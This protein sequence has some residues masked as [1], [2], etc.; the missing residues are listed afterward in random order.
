MCTSCVGLPPSN[1]GGT[2]R[3]G[4]INRTR[5]ANTNPR[6]PAFSFCVPTNTERNRDRPADDAKTGLERC[7][8]D[9]QII[10][11]QWPQSDVAAGV[12]AGRLPAFVGNTS[13]FRVYLPLRD[14]DGGGLLVDAG[15]R[16]D[17]HRHL[18][19]TTGTPACA[20]NSL[21][22]QYGLRPGRGSAV[23]ISMHGRSV[24]PGF[25]VIMSLPGAASRAAA[26][27][28]RVYGHMTDGH[29]SRSLAAPVRRR[30]SNLVSAANSPEGTSPS[31]TLADRGRGWPILLS[32]IAAPSGRRCY[33]TRSDKLEGILMPEL[34][35]ALWD[36]AIST[37]A[38]GSLMHRLQLLKYPIARESWYTGPCLPHN[39]VV[40][41]LY[42]HASLIRPLSRAHVLR[43]STSSI[44]F[45]KAGR[46]HSRRAS[47]QVRAGV[48]ALVE[49]RFRG[50]HYASGGPEKRACYGLVPIL[51][52]FLWNEGHSI[53]GFTT[54]V[55]MLP[56]TRQ[57]SLSD[58]APQLLSA[59]CAWRPQRTP[60]RSS[61]V[62]EKGAG[63]MIFEVWA[64]KSRT[65]RVLKFLV[66]VSFSTANYAQRSCISSLYDGEEGLQVPATRV[67][68]V[69]VKVLFV[70]T[71]LPL[72]YLP[73]TGPPI[74][75]PR[76][77]VRGQPCSPCAGGG[78][79]PRP[80]PRSLIKRA[81]KT[82]RTVVYSRPVGIPRRFFHWDYCNAAVGF[83]P[84]KLATT[85]ENALWVVSEDTHGHTF[86]VIDALLLRDT[87]RNSQAIW[88]EALYTGRSFVLA[89]A[90]S[91][92]PGVKSEFQVDVTITYR[93]LVLAFRKLEGYGLSCFNPLFVAS[94]L[95]QTG[96]EPCNMRAIAETKISRPQLGRK[97]AASRWCIP[98]GI[99]SRPGGALMESVRHTDMTSTNPSGGVDLPIQLQ[100]VSWTSLSKLAKY[101]AS[102]RCDC[103]CQRHFLGLDELVNLEPPQDRRDVDGVQALSPTKVGVWH[104]CRP[105]GD[106]INMFEGNGLVW[107]DGTSQP[108][109]RPTWVLSEDIKAISSVTVAHPRTWRFL[110]SQRDIIE[111]ASVP[112]IT[113]WSINIKRRR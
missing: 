80:F 28:E 98:V 29:T 104:K 75:W 99:P 20:E 10:S 51:I 33:L 106:C 58:V 78:A 57:V 62:E 38:D 45:N 53:G 79:R 24:A 35:Y 5:R 1:W 54:Q 86:A 95:F 50:S 12:L 83:L 56:Q 110:T 13:N 109:G 64:A 16:I 40:I 72:E 65:I 7:L 107:I 76:T 32:V 47:S 82:N 18:G 85:V 6:P 44:T 67:V 88:D 94:S 17:R 91:W 90:P 70:L 31:F 93:F 113:G 22:A 71:G 4:V 60:R 46:R 21:L 48:P 30:D 11:G 9:Y 59:K 69:R 14:L 73:S 55:K 15:G 37:S 63:V 96:D 36:A 61:R 25:P 101:N 68:N 34:L 84:G 3:V 102:A 19:I 8:R 92:K 42:K 108:L 27:G 97:M 49:R 77:C 112:H 39:T 74:D 2:R 41:P 52:A 23:A 66:L 43:W 26:R 111:S 103:R 89:C 105:R 87:R 100:A 81:S